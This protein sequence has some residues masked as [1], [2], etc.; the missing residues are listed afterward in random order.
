MLLKT[1]LRLCLMTLLL[2]SLSVTGC[3]SSGGSFC[4]T[5]R[6]IYYESD[7]QVD[8]TPAGINRQVREHNRKFRK[9]CGFG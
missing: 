3:A 2:T 4:D 1:K 6:P 5:A 9:V 7:E 8:Q